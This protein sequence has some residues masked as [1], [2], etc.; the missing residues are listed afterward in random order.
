MPVD[1]DGSITSA[2]SHAI[3]MIMYKRGRIM[4]RVLGDVTKQRRHTV[5]HTYFLTR[6]EPVLGP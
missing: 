6:I 2:N 3:I 4:K 5:Y 1:A